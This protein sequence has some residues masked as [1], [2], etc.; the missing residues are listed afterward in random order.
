MSPLFSLKFSPIIKIN[1][2]LLLEILGSATFPHSNCPK[3]ERNGALAKEC[4]SN[5]FLLMSE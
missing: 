1:F 4:F 3:N 2:F 5:F